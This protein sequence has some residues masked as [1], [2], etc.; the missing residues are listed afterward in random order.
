MSQRKAKQLLHY[1]VILGV[2]RLKEILEKYTTCRPYVVVHYSRCGQ[3]SFKLTPGGWA[4]VID[5]QDL[6][7]CFFAVLIKY[8]II[9]HVTTNLGLELLNTTSKNTC[10]VPHG[11]K[12]RAFL[13]IPQSMNDETIK[14]SC[15]IQRDALYGYYLEQKSR[16]GMLE[17]S[18]MNTFAQVCDEN[19]QSNKFCNRFIRMANYVHLVMYGI[20][21]TKNK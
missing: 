8:G 7:E 1:E 13:T 12:M 14:H 2:G 5:K 6:V 3:L 11:C 15:R 20:N 16:C 21:N 9:V 4:F 18:F 10:C 17:S 19:I